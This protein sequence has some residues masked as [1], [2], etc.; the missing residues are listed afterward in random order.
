MLVMEQ[1]WLTSHLRS[2]AGAVT[3][4]Q[5]VKHRV[6]AD[7]SRRASDSRGRLLG[8]MASNSRAIFFHMGDGW[9]QG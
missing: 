2:F 9:L 1:E 6:R 8:R 5:V 4:S 3:V 7:S